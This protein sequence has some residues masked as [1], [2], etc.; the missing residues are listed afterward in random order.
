M[1]DAAY[2]IS[3]RLRFKGKIATICVAVSFLVMII[4]MAISSG[5]RYEIRSALSGLSGDI[6]ISPV[7]M[8]ILNEDNP[9]GS[10]AAYIPY[11]DRISSVRSIVPAVYRAGIVKHEE[12]M[13]GVL[14]KGTAEVHWADSINLGVSIPSDLAKASGLRKGDKMLTYFVGEKMKVR[15][16]IVE[17]IYDA[18][19]EE[20]GNAIVYASLSD[21]QRLNGWAQ[22]QVSAIEV[23][24]YPEYADEEGIRAVTDEVGTTINAY[25]SEDDEHVVATS[26]VSRYPQVFNWLS[27]IDFNVFFI[28]LLMIVVAGFNMISGLLIIL[29]ENTSVIGLLKSLGMRDWSIIKVFLSGSAVIVAKGMAI[30]NLLAA[31]LCIIQK[32]THIL[33]LDPENYY[34]SFVPVHLDSG[35]ILLADIISFV[36]IMLLLLLPCIFISRVDPAQTVR[37]S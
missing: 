27:L 11:I 28:L 5:F 1:M 2:F 26:S 32:T 6:L 34:V 22:D 18:L 35:T 9:I 4:A 12:G 20:D 29:F 19:W 21:M 14:V 8:D 16:F 23:R 30:G 31:G 7:D 36:V 24:L 15:Q 13:H 17:D 3:G 33:K 25:I 37:V 10:D